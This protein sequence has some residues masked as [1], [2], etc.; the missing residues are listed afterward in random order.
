[1]TLGLDREALDEYIELN[2]SVDTVDELVKRLIASG[3][4]PERI[5][6]RC[7][8]A[9]NM[10]RTGDLHLVFENV[11]RTGNVCS[12]FVE[13]IAEAINNP[14]AGPTTT[15]TSTTITAFPQV[16]KKG[17]KE[18]GREGGISILLITGSPVCNCGS[19]LSSCGD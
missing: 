15:M 5:L 18:G 6:R 16:R 11:N 17:G 14:E 8:M 4:I 9:V 12:M 7:K 2:P 10:L 19:D 3:F 1:M 13:E